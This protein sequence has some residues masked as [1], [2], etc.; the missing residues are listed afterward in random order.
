MSEG[1]AFLVP[2]T[3]DATAEAATEVP[4]KFR[5]VQWTRLAGGETPAAF[6]TRV[7]TLLGRPSAAAAPSPALTSQPAGF[8]PATPP[9]S[10]KRLVAGAL[11]AVVVI[12]TALFFTRHPA[13]TDKSIAVLPFENMS[14]DKDSGYFADGMHEDILTNLAHIRELRVVSRTSVMEYR[15]TKG[16]L[17]GIAKKLGVA[18]IL[19]GSVRRAGSKVRVTGQLIR[20]TTDEHL[21]A[22]TIDRD[23]TVADVFAIQ[24]ELAQKIAASLEA[25]LSPQEKKLLTRRPTENLAAYDAFLKG[26]ELANNSQN[27]KAGLQKQE[28]LY[29]AAVTLDEKFAAAWGELAATHV[30]IKT[31]HIDET[32]ALR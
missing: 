18:Y 28:D 23:L 3:I 9:R 29:Q 21:W 26:R 11:A 10:A 25:V 24:S 6:V 27:D 5:D 22:E 7:Q 16:N 12:A 4:E 13:A 15:G 32:P 8:S 14:D 31:S 1:K 17:R 2:V 30:K 19:E 20:A